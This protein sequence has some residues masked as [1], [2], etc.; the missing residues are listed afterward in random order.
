MSTQNTIVFSVGPMTGRSL[1]EYRGRRHVLLVLYTLPLSRPRLER[2]AGGYAL[3]SALGA[4]V[5]AVPR[6]AAADAIRRLGSRP[7]VF[8]PVVTEGAADIVEAYRLLGDAPHAEFLI[9]RLGYVR[10]RWTTTAAG[11]GDFRR[12]S[13]DLERLNAE[14]VTAP[15]AEAHAH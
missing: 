14:P 11:E 8:F 9:D 13:S 1:R 7:P 5:I 2:L 3:L 4:E 6:D 10:T 15:P 12:L